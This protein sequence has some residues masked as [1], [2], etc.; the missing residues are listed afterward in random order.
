[1]YFFFAF[2]DPTN[3]IRDCTEL[4]P[5]AVS[6]TYPFQIECKDSGCLEDLY[7]DM[8]TSGGGWTVN[9]RKNIG[10]LYK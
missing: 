8:D 2:P 5:E 1:M 3:K 6:G 4:F 10:K 7:C 9:S